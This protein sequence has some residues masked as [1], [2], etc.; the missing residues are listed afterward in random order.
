MFVVLYGVDHDVFSFTFLV[1]ENKSI[2]HHHFLLYGSCFLPRRRKESRPLTIQII[3]VS[4][5][6]LHLPF[7]YREKRGMTYV[8]GPCLVSHLRVFINNSLTF[9]LLILTLRKDFVLIL[10]G[11]PISFTSMNRSL[12]LWIPRVVKRNINF[13]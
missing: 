5:W 12:L 10:S 4:L 7:T 9:L 1:I 13:I 8:S 6:L 3:E 11:T 2:W